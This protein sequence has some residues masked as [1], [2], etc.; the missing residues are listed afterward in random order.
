MCR[1]FPA[2]PLAPVLLSD[3]DSICYVTSE[4]SVYLSD[5]ALLSFLS[6]SSAALRSIYKSCEKRQKRH[7]MKATLTD[8]W[9]WCFVRD[10]MQCTHVLDERK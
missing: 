10:I 1:M 6:A 8:L 2:R 9:I 3:Q 7:L 4:A 5:A